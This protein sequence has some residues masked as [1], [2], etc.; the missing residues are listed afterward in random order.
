[1]IGIIRVNA[2]GITLGLDV[3]TELGY[4]DVY[5]DGLTMVSLNAYCLETHCVIL[6]VN[7]F[8]LTKSSN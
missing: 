1:M 8:A 3:E 4:L 2:Y 5:F 7:C 6:V